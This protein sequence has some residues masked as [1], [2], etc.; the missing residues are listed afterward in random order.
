[1]FSLGNGVGGGDFAVRESG[2]HVTIPNHLFL[3]NDSYN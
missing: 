2:N 3:S 1:M